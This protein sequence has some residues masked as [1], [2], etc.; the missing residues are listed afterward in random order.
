[1]PVGS[2]KLPDCSKC[3]SAEE[4]PTTNPSSEVAF[5]NAVF[6]LNTD[7]SI[8]T[9][10]GPRKSFRHSSQPHE[11]EIYDLEPQCE[12]C[13][14]SD[15]SCTAPAADAAAQEAIAAH[16]KSFTVCSLGNVRS[17]AQL[18][19]KHRSITRHR[20]E[21]ITG[22]LHTCRWHDH[23]RRVPICYGRGPY[24]DLF[25]FWSIHKCSLRKLL[26]PAHVRLPRLVAEIRRAVLTDSAGALELRCMPW[27]VW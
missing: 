16:P 7:S 8:N 27:S 21:C 17:K 23:Y 9:R 10:T 20:S 14:S 1:M 2:L 18:P 4:A 25:C 3:C 22:P 19:A 11:A 26:L 24:D 13:R 12:K 5:G 15:A 6:L